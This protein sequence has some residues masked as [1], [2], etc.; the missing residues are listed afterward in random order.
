MTY[1]REIVASDIV[2]MLNPNLKYLTL[3]HIPQRMKL[4]DHVRFFDDKSKN[5]RV[6]FAVTFIDERNGYRFARLK[7][8]STCGD[9]EPTCNNLRSVSHADEIR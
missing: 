9:L 2:T 1:D 4:G 7:K 6:D 8:V 3:T 5:Y